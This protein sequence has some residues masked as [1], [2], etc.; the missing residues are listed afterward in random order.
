MPGLKIARS[1]RTAVPVMAEMSAVG[2]R[3]GTVIEREYC[4]SPRRNGLVWMKGR[5]LAGVP[6]LLAQLRGR[7]ACELAYASI[8]SGSVEEANCV[9][10]A[11]AGRVALIR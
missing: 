6:V 3:S 1:P 2:R 11:N 9:T 4:V 7:A 10:A 8:S 5:H